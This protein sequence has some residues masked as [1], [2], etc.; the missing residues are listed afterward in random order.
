MVQPTSSLD[1]AVE[2]ALGVGGLNRLS[3]RLD[4][5]AVPFQ[6]QSEFLSTLYLAASANPWRVPSLMESQRRQ[7]VTTVSSPAATLSLASRWIGAGARRDLLGNPAQIYSSRIPASRPLEVTLERYRSRGLVTEIPNLSG[8]PNEVQRA[9]ALILDCALANFGNRTAAFS[10]IEN[11][12]SEFE[13]ETLGEWGTDDPMATKRMLRLYRNADLAFLFAAAQDLAAVSRMATTM[14]TTTSPRLP[15]SVTIRTSWG[16]ILLSGGSDSVYNDDRPYL[17]IIDTGGDDVYLNSPSNRSLSNWISVVIDSTGDDQYL[18][19]PSLGGQPI[20]QFSSRKEGVAKLGPGSAL[21]GISILID[22]QGKDLYRT[23]RNGIGSATFGVAVVTDD[24][25]NDLYDSYARSQGYGRFGIGLL[26]DAKGDD[27]YRIFSE[28][29]GFGAPGGVGLLIDREGSDQYLAN[30]SVIDRPSPEDAKVPISMVQGCGSGVRMDFVNGKSLAGGVGA[31]L[32]LDGDDRYV[33]GSYGQGVGYWCG[34][35]VLW[36]VQGKDRYQVSRF[37]IGA[38]TQ[39]GVGYFDEGAGDDL[40]QT[41]GNLTLGAAQDYALGI[42]VERGGNDSYSGGSGSLGFATA[43]G[44]GVFI[45]LLGQ[46]RYETNGLTL[47]Q[48]EAS[49]SGTVR[50]RS[51]ALGLFLDL[52]GSNNYPS[53]VS[54]ARNGNRHAEIRNRGPNPWESQLGIFF[55]RSGGL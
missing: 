2:T 40:Y 13:R 44:I 48:A 7:L 9:A 27:E 6:Q 22:R 1:N 43:N 34:I 41:P 31:L 47:G 50:E 25:G 20:A 52:Q 8:V 29:Q 33:A 15:Y 55:D 21:F 28:G 12:A 17:L 16:D 45:D 42:L 54:W 36:D 19:E 53:S 46:D 14:V 3:A 24:S 5:T 4:E 30:L 32:D 38:A 10:A 37:G 11:L 49:Q 35:G 39:F 23:H 51:L 26:E 18:S